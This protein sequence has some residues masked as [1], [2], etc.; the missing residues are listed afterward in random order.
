VGHPS[1][2][3]N[4]LIRHEQLNLI[5]C[6]D[7]T[8]PPGTRR[9]RLSALVC[10]AGVQAISPQRTNE[11]L[12]I[13]FATNHLGHFLLSRLLLDD[14]SRGQI[15]FVSSATHDPARRTGMPA[16][17]L[18]D[19]RTIAFGNDNAP[20]K[21]G[22]AGRIRYTTSKLYNVLCAYE[23]ARRLGAVA[24]SRHRVSV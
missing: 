2:F 6:K 21:A 15:A 14:L 11:G 3:R 18:R 10:N 24:D 17:N 23:F 19:V 9:P 16:P 20:L 4:S 5:P 8:R 22:E 13:T 7:R 12:E 1:C